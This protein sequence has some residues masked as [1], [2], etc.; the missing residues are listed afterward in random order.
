MRAVAFTVLRKRK[1]LPAGRS[2]ERSG[3]RSAQA[4]LPP[5]SRRHQAQNV[6]GKVIALQGRRG[7]RGSQETAPVPP[8]A[9]SGRSRARCRGRRLRS[10]ARGGGR[11]RRAMRSR[12]RPARGA[13]TPR[14][15]SA[16][17][18]RS[19][20]ASEPSRARAR[21]E[22]AARR[23]RPR[24]AR[25]SS[26]AP[27][28]DVLVQPSATTRPSR[29]STATTS[30]SPNRGAARGEEVGRERGRADHDPRGAGGERGL[31]R[32][33][34]PVAAADL[35]RLPPAAATRS[36]SPGV[37]VPEKAPSR[38]TRC[39]NARTLAREARARPPPGRRPRSSRARGRPCEPD[40]RVLRA[41]RSRAGRVE[42]L[43]CSHVLAC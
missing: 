33:D 8:R 13:P 43:S 28:T 18:S 36:T 31:D 4:T 5:R 11:G 39:R 35:H 22:Q 42:A 7:P 40:A 25:A 20:P 26:P 6:V 16:S 27:T 37:G 3:M 23:R 9:R 21:H 32:R 17:S 30:R 34:R 15:T 12:R 38:S 41:R 19:G 1:D 24:S 14:S 29:A 10:R 2:G